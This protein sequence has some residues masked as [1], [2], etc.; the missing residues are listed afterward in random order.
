[1]P[2]TLYRIIRLTNLASSRLIDSQ[3]RISKVCELMVYL[4]VSNAVQESDLMGN[5]FF[6]HQY[7]FT[8]YIDH[9]DNATVR[10]A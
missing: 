9:N 6:I 4:L 1:M 5:I 10:A 2:S 7:L 3:M 8:R